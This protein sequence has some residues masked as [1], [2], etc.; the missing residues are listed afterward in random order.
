MDHIEIGIE[1][2]GPKTTLC[3]EISSKNGIIYL[4]LADYVEIRSKNGIISLFL[5]DCVEISSKNGTISIFFDDCVEIRSKKGII[6]EIRLDFGHLASSLNG[7][8]PGLLK[9]K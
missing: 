4:F 9:L 2:K 6:C 8:N 1:P 7:Q 3:V 5:V